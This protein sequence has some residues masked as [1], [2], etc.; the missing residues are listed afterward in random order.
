M[1]AHKS[2]IE[3]V[4][5]GAKRYYDRGMQSLT[6]QHIWEKYGDAPFWTVYCYSIAAGEAYQFYHTMDWEVA[7]M[8][9]VASLVGVLWTGELLDHRRN[10]LQSSAHKNQSLSMITR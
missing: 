1:T 6:P 4:I 2:N 5:D 9:A 10:Y 7:G 3:T 8:A